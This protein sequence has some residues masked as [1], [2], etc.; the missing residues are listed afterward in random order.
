MRLS[1]PKRLTAFLISCIAAIII[2]AGA[3]QP[4]PFVDNLLQVA[5]IILAVALVIGALNVVLVHLRALRNRMPGLGY[6]LVLVVA[7]ITVF[8]LEIV[9]PLVGGSIGATTTAISTRAY[10]YI[11]Q[12]L[13]MS[14]LGLLVFF[15]LQATW[16]ALA[17]RPG[18]A[19]IVVIVAVVFLVGSG[20]W[21]ALVPGLPEMLAWMTIYPANGVARGLLLGISIGAV[22]TTVRLLLGFD[23]PYLD[24]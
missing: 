10:Q 20:P 18:E 7:A 22:V 9:A 4:F 14:V 1:D 16:R 6:R 15:A 13:A 3:I 17:T 24:R 5:Q 11:Y 8:A 19:W 12:P 2:L 23:Q 21:A